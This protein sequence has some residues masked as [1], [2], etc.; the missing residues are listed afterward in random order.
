MMNR[1]IKFRGKKDEGN[2]W[3]YGYLVYMEDYIFDYSERIDIPYIV[4]FNNF[5]LK[6]YREYR[7]EEKTIGQFT[8]LYDKNNT[9]IYEGDL[10]EFA[11]EK[12]PIKYGKYK[13]SACDE[14]YCERIGYYIKTN[15]FGSHIKTNT[16]IPLENICKRY[17]IV[18][19]IHDEM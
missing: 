9:P 5:N 13:F 7:V 15:N 12:C 11:N 3:I 18:G 17:K 4:P 8:G 6:D 16:G 2:E 19:T 14:Y 10:I 1:E